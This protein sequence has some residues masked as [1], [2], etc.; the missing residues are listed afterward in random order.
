MQNLNDSAFHLQMVR[1]ADH[2]IGEGRVPLDGWFPNLSLGSSFFHHYQSL[3]DTLTAYAARVTGAGDH[4]TYLWILYLLLA[5][6]PISVYLGARLLDWDRWTAAAA[7][8]VSPLIV[9]ASGYGYEHGSY[10]L[11]GYGVYSQLWAMWLLPLA[12]GL[13]WRAVSRGKYYAAAAAALALTIA[14]HFITGYLAL[15]TVGVWVLVA[16]GAFL[17]RVG[18]AA[19]VVARIVARGRRGCSCRSLA[20]AKWSTQSEFYKGSVFNDSYGAGKVLGWLFT[21][22]LFDHGRFPIVTL[23]FFVGVARVR[24]RERGATCAPGRCSARS[25]SACCSSSAVRRWGRCWISCPASTT[26]RS[27]ASSWESISPASCSR[28]SGSAWLLRTASRWA[29]RRH[30]RPDR[31]A[32]VRG[33]RSGCVTGGMRRGPG[34]RLD[35]AR[36]LRPARSDAHRMPSGRPREPTAATSTGWSRS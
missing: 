30:G 7:A 23:L 29:A 17:P 34:A 8:A 12:W 14:C 16:R 27:T 3:P 21:G 31:A 26:S 35:R 20:D 25:L 9:S 18:R 33:G 13:T 36:R 5:L 19:V 15:L 28:A 32:R 6:W 4:S 11:R 1:W 24:G 22:G 10:I 2:Q